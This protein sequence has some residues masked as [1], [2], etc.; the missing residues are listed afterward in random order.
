MMERLQSENN[1]KKSSDDISLPAKRMHPEVL[2]DASETLNRRQKLDPE[3]KNRGY[4]I[5]RV[6]IPVIISTKENPYKAATAKKQ[7]SSSEFSNNPSQAAKTISKDKSELVDLTEDYPSMPKQ[8]AP[9]EK[10]LDF[11][12]PTISKVV[13]NNI[14]AS[15]TLKIPQN[16]LEENNPDDRMDIESDTE[17]ENYK[18]LRVTVYEDTRTV[19]DKDE[20]F[21]LCAENRVLERFDK[22]VKKCREITN[23]KRLEAADVLRI[24]MGNDGDTKDTLQYF[25]YK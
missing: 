18:N 2:I 9:I 1:Q 3:N 25:G 21:N 11:S 14:E 5:P 17:I 6:C 24:L 4:Y 10:K 20:L 13:M 23:N 22:L 15:E 7:S 12:T 16:T 8:P 19:L